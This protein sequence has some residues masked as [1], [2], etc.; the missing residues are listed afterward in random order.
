MGLGGL[1]VKIALRRAGGRDAGFT[2][3]EILL[4]ITI[5]TIGMLAVAQMQITAIKGIDLS[6]DSSTATN[7]AQQQL[8]A[9]LNMDYDSADLNDANAANNPGS[10]GNLTSTAVTD[11]QATVDDTGTVDASGHYTLTWNVA[12]D[13]PIQD[14][15]SVAVIVEWTTRGKQHRRVLTCIK[16]MAS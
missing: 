14:T 9:I 11:H 16:S 10:G 15:K 7:L 4:A 2:L 13:E 12:D 3:L 6:G 5:L 1:R 8:E